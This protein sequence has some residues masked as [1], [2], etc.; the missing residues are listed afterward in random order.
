MGLTEGEVLKALDS[1]PIQYEVHTHDAVPTVDAQVR[2][3]S[4][5]LLFQ[6]LIGIAYVQAA[7]LSVV[8][9]VPTKNLFL[10]V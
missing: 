9:G 1:L 8:D 6:P 3:A 5:P 4:G 7:A 10:K 2:S